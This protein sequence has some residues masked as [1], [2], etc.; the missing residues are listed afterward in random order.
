MRMNDGARRVRT[1]AVSRR[2]RTTGR[3]GRETRDKARV[4]GILRACMAIFFCLSGHERGEN[5]GKIHTFRTEVF[6]DRR[7]EDS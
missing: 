1:Q 3:A 7:A 6:T 5:L 4:V 2:S